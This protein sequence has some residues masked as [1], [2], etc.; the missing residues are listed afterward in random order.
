MSMQLGLLSLVIVMLSGCGASGNIPTWP[1]CL[2]EKCVGTG[3]AMDDDGLSKGSRIIRQF[4]S[5]NSPARVR[6]NAMFNDNGSISWL[7]ETKDALDRAVVLAIAEDS[8]PG[9][10]VG[11]AGSV[12]LIILVLEGSSES[13]VVNIDSTG[14]HIGMLQHRFFNKRLAAL[15]LR[16]FAVME[17]REDRKK[18]IEDMLKTVA[19]SECEFGNSGEDTETRQ[20]D[21][22]RD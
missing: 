5:R 6:M 21:G 9:A 12:T 20:E 4:F 18:T 7:T 8:K 19:G 1:A 11:V 3:G 22:S 13:L 16:R 14:A 17:M 2:D 15:L 10:I